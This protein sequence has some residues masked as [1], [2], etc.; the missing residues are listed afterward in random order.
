[1]SLL[2][3]RI[4]LREPLTIGVHGRVA[5]VLELAR[6]A[7]PPRDHADQHWTVRAPQHEGTPAV[8]LTRVDPAVAKARAHHAGENPAIISATFIPRGVVD[9][10]PHPPFNP[11][12]PLPP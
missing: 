9:I 12:R 8:A 7:F 4:G 10:T 11:P 2:V 6:T 5:A 3:R 1:G